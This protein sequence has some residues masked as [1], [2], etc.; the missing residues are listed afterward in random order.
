MPEQERDRWLLLLSYLQAMVYHDRGEEEHDELSRV[1]VSTVRT[2]ARR[3]EV[4]AMIRSMADVLEEQGMKKGLEQGR[5]E[6]QLSKSQETLLRQLR[7]RFGRLP[8]AVVQTIR[9]T[10]DV[11]RLDTWLERFADASTLADVGIGDEQS[12]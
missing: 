7:I 12:T 11:Q 9:A 3:K 10:Q 2:D 6:G 5:M 8:R 4:E 1:I